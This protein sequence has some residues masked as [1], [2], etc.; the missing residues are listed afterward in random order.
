AFLLLTLFRRARD[1]GLLDR[2]TIR[3]PVTQEQIADTVGF[4]LVHTNKTIGKLRRSGA[5][6]WVGDSFTMLDEAML[7]RLAGNP[8]TLTAA[9]PFI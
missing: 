6:L 1:V 4:S 8:V 3:L 9:R 7:A 5:F 2:R